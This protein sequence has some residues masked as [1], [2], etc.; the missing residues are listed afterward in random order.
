MFFNYEL[1]QF[2]HVGS[3]Y[4]RVFFALTIVFT[5]PLFQIRYQRDFSTRLWGKT[6]EKESKETQ[7]QVCAQ[8]KAFDLISP[9]FHS[10]KDESK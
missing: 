4:E 6:Q 2:Q 3:R 8:L 9:A 10:I 7:E 5:Y 1:A